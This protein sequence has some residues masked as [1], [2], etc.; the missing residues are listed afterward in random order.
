MWNQ[1]EAIQLCKVIENIAPFFGCHVAL[2]GGLLYKSGPRKDCDL[3]FYRIRQV[4]KIDQAGL[5]SALC[6]IG[7]SLHT[8]YGWLLKARYL[9]R[10]VDMLFPENEGTMYPSVD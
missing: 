10:S 9:G 8:D 6:V 5:L 1:S 7:F 3:I 4:E 2:T